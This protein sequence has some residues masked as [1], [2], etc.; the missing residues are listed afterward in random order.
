MAIERVQRLLGGL[1]GVAFV[2]HVG[3]GL[4]GARLAWTQYTLV[5]DTTRDVFFRGS[6]ISAQLADLADLAYFDRGLVI[7]TAVLFIALFYLLYRDLPTRSRRAD[8]GWLGWVVPFANLYVP[9]RLAKE[10]DAAGSERETNASWTVFLWWT[11][12]LTSRLLGLVAGLAERDGEFD[13]AA[14]MDLVA[15]TASALSALC[16]LVLVWRW[17]FAHPNGRSRTA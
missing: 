9:F 16:A 10:I 8:W 12:W 13:Q 1:C 2:G 7:V 4:L 11:M 3:L 15:S 14:L 17:V 5:S 6:A